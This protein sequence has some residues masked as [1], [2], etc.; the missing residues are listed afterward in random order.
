MEVFLIGVQV[1]SIK[2]PKWIWRKNPK[3]H[4]KVLF[5]SSTI[6]NTVVLLSLTGFDHLLSLVL[7]LNLTFVFLFSIVFLSFAYTLSSIF[8]SFFLIS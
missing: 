1:G 5:K 7:R 2:M 4:K 8:N 6:S 3:P